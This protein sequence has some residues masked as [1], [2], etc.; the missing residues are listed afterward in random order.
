MTQTPHTQNI[1]SGRSP[2]F[3]A[4]GFNMTAGILKYGKGL[5]PAIRA[6]Q[7][8]LFLGGY[9]NPCTNDFLAQF[10]GWFLNSYRFTH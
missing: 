9:G 3:T 10:L 2:A 4:F 5:V 7:E 8:T 6:K 1:E